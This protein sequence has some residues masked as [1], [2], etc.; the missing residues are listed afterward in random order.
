MGRTYAKVK[1]LPKPPKK[2]GKNEQAR[3]DYADK[4]APADVNPDFE[5]D[6][7]TVLGAMLKPV[8]E[9]KPIKRT[10]KKRK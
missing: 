7:D 5:K 1:R 6:F 2:L 4:V 8:E 10:Y 3:K 9:S